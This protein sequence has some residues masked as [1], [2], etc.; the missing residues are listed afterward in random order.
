PSLPETLSWVCFTGGEPTLDP[1]RLVAGIAACTS[2]RAPPTLLTH[3]KWIAKP[4]HGDRLMARL[5]EAGLR[6]FGISYDEYHD[7]FWSLE[8]TK[9]C[10][11]KAA[12]FGFNITVKLVRT[13][14][15]AESLRDEFL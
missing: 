11:A 8:R 2:A 14:N 3:G 7:P 9:E 13:P 5:W 12:G 4:R 6:A 1:E 10:V 15:Y